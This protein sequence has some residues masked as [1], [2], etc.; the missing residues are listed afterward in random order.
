MADHFRRTDIDRL[1][2]SVGGPHLSIYM[3]TH[4]L[5][6]DVHQDMLRLKNLKH[7]ADKV[8]ND[9]WMSKRDVSEFTA[10]IEELM[11]DE[12]FWAQRQKG[13]AIFRTHSDFRVYRLNHSFEERLA[14][15]RNYLFRPI[16]PVLHENAAGYVLALSENNVEIFHVDETSIRIV[17]VANMPS[18]LQES[19]NYTSVDRGQQAHTGSAVHGGK[20]S[21]VFHGQGGASD[22]HHQDLQYFFR[23]VDEAVGKIIKDSGEPLILACVDS[24]VPIYREANSYSGLRQKH[25]SGNADYLAHDDLHRKAL[26]ILLA[27]KESQQ[28]SQLNLICEHLNTSKASNKANDVIRA[29]YQGRVHTL[30]FDRDAIVPG[31]FDPTFQTPVVLEDKSELKHPSFNTDLVE[32]AVEQTLRHRG[33][34]YSVSKQ[35]MPGSAPLSALMRY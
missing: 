35:D 27:E 12:G 32:A 21:M 5:S 19:L 20:K 4:L 33:E 25:I 10:P 22:S 30:F 28:K 3:P 17:P 13:L 26:A 2:A 31:R 1:V 6:S 29:S 15:S 23:A 18:S 11:H 9:N 34:V 24:S 16:V 7:E 14:I 8:L